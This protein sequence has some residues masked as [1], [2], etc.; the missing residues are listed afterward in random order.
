MSW[1]CWT[2]ADNVISVGVPMPSLSDGAMPTSR[3]FISSRVVGL[4]FCAIA[5]TRKA[6]VSASGRSR[7]K[8]V[9]TRPLEVTEAETS[10]DAA[11]DGF[12]VAWLITPPVEPRPNSIDDGPISTSTASSAKMSR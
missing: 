2:N 1:L 3:F 7:S 9:R 6:A 12:F 11:S 4:P 10:V 8:V 5:A